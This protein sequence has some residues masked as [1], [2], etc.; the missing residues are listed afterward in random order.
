MDNPRHHD[1]NET[2][3]TAPSSPSSS[4]SGSASS[5][6]MFERTD[7][8]PP[9]RIGDYR[10]LRELGRGG[11]G[12][13]YLAVRDDDRFHKR[14]AIKVIRKGMD[15]EDIL[16]RFDQER[17]VLGA[18]NH[19]NIARLLDGGQTDDGRPF[20]VVE[21]VEGLPLDKH[22]DTHRLKISERL[23]L[24]RTVCAAVHY[25]H[26]NLV[27]HRDLKPSNILVTSAGEVKLL[28][29]GIAKLLNPDLLAF[30]QAPTAPE[31]RLMT[32]EYASPEQVRGDP[33]TTASDV[34]SLG[35]LLYELLTGHRPYRIKT[36]VLQEVVRVIC[37]VEPERPSAAVTRV[38]EVPDPTGTAGPGA[39][40]ATR[41]LGPVEVSRTREGRPER[42]RR[43]LT[44]DID[45]IVLMAMRKEPQRRY[46]SAL[47]LSEDLQRHLNGHPV[48]ARPD[49][50]IY[51]AR[52]FI[53]RN[54][55]SVAAAAAIALA[56][57]IGLAGMTW[58]RN[59]AVQERDRADRIAGGMTQMSGLLLRVF[60]EID[61]FR[62]STARREMFVKDVRDSLQALADDAPTSP[63]AARTLAAAHGVLGDVQG[64]IRGPSVGK[65]EEA[66]ASYTES[67]R[68]LTPLLEADPDP[69][70]RSDLAAALLALADAQNAALDAETARATYARA[71]DMARQSLAGGKRDV[72]SK[73]VLAAA[74]L[75]QGD[76]LRAAADFKG[77]RD[78]YQE[79]FAIRRELIGA[80]PTDPAEARDLSTA[81]GRFAQLSADLGDLDGAVQTMRES[82]A[83]RLKILEQESAPTE[84][85]N[86]SVRAPRDVMIG[87]LTL[88]SFLSERGDTEE[89]ITT[90]RDAVARAKAVRDA[91][92]DNIRGPRD[93][94]IAQK[95]LADAQLDADR[96]E[97]ALREYRAAVGNAQDAVRTAPS[98]RVCNESLRDARLASAKAMLQLG[99][100]R[101]ALAELIAANEVSSTLLAAD[102]QRRSHQLAAAEIVSAIALTRWAE[103]PATG[104]NELRAAYDNARTL[105]DA[106]PDDATGI[107]ILADA[108][109]ALAWSRLLADQPADARE[110]FDAILKVTEAAAKAEGSSRS[111]RASHAETLA[112]LAM[113]LAAT[114]ATAALAAA[115]Q[116]RDA[117]PG[118][119]ARV[120]WAL[121]TAQRAAGDPSSADA[122]L[123]DALALIARAP[124]GSPDARLRA[125]IEQA[126]VAP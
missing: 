118:P 68:L 92:P 55:V 36:R 64:G 25:A 59:L 56:L 101:D 57:A 52:K 125:A 122:T 48:D 19:P 10:V 106:A 77:A 16:K 73:R 111:A 39:A 60:N 105:A 113:V 107:A 124:A 69:K 18:M 88:G 13:V 112:G 62:S 86:E 38:E 14:V 72:L 53:V 119:S 41:T 5:R 93:L 110:A 98:D 67:V 75:K 29:F 3:A 12:M 47:A 99:R 6:R 2:S 37:E 58:Q 94:S 126:R 27:V 24:F 31:L 89:A 78:A 51:R 120:L 45:N 96:I 117:A 50:P 123:A 109:L 54:R 84:P 9:E 121:S 21:Y 35:V 46:A 83:I 114:D 49:S 4:G 100:S 61:S 103:S 33:L 71:A 23:D 104:L 26:Q 30:T 70:L 74:L 95:R 17:Q 87:L 91:M 32:P 42:L 81:L 7:E 20:F 79:S 22:C 43:R 90:L 65:P 116:A 66:L 80:E 28:D 85:R 63:A 34:Y 11:M 97:E 44:G 76:L 108:G 102:P 1:P 82:V 8:A 15:S 40:T 115:N